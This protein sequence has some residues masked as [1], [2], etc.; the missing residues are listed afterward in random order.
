MTVL[1]G[2]TLAIVAVLAWL[3]LKAGDRYDVAKEAYGEAV[4]DADRFEKLEPY[5]TRENLSAK[6]VALDQYRESA[7]DLQQK[8]TPY[9]PGEL[10]NISVEDFAEQLKAARD[11]TLAAFGDKTTVP[12]DYYM[13]FEAYRAAVANGNATGIL[14]YQLET[15]KKMLLDMAK[16]GVSQVVNIHRPRL[17]EELGQP[18]KAADDQVARQLP[19]ELTFR[20]SEAA[21]REFL[22]TLINAEGRYITV[23]SLSVRN[24]NPEPP[25]TADA[26]FERMATS[27]AATAPVA[28]AAVFGG[29]DLGSLFES[30]DAAPAGGESEA[31][32]A[33]PKPAEPVEPVD[34]SRI[35]SQVLGNEELVV[36]A[37]IDILILLEPKELP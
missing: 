14:V 29:T 36:F 23:R 7:A 4:D 27:R 30:S 32:P 33:A 31:K 28:P 17:E 2:G 35:L 3:G 16:A 1:T 15:V 19:V 37:R 8:F 6:K 11:E 12:E 5:P 26:Q 24:T 21:V 25:N 10:A 22:A 18:F 9:Q 13:G 20:G 34:S